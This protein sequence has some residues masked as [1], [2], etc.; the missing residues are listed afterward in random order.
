MAEPA[1]PLP[2]AAQPARLL[3]LADALGWPLLVLSAAGRVE[4]ANSAGQ[5]VLD[6]AAP[7]Y[8]TAAQDGRVLPSAPSAAAGFKQAVQQAARGETVTLA[9]PAAVHEGSPLAHTADCIASLQPLLSAGEAPQPGRV[10][11]SLDTQ[12]RPAPDLHSY[13]Q[14]LTLT[15]AQARVLHSLAHG[16]RPAQIAAALG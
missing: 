2:T 6:A 15:P 8:C 12:R 11:L 13:A 16:L 7:V 1:P 5:A 3:R 14:A 4:Q 9:L 10:L